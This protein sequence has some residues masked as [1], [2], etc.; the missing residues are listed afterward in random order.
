MIIDVIDPFLSLPPAQRTLFYLEDDSSLKPSD[1]PRARIAS[2]TCSSGRD[3]IDVGGEIFPSAKNCAQGVI[4]AHSL[5]REF[6]GP[7]APA[8]D[9]YNGI[10]LQ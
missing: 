1:W 9:T 8:K 7:R 10:V 3:A 2:L 6:L 4:H 5:L